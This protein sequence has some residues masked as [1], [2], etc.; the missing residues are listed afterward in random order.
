MGWKHMLEAYP[1]VAV[2]SN[3]SLTSLL[4]KTK[5]I[6]NIVIIKASHLDILFP[7]FYQTIQ[8]FQLYSNQATLFYQSQCSFK[9][10]DFIF[11]FIFNSNDK[12]NFDLNS[13][14]MSFLHS[15]I[16]LSYSYLQQF[17]N[18]TDLLSKSTFHH[19]YDEWFKNINWFR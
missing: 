9:P 14:F 1:F 13:S 16:T 15:Q 18:W 2:K 4:S 7:S 11:G 12:N 3:L 6:D 5:C 17:S 19:I 10:I 8:R